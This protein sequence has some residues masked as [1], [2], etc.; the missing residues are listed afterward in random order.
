D[1]D[2]LG[3]LAVDASAKLNDER[4]DLLQA[5]EALAAELSGEPDPV[6]RSEEE[7]RISLRQLANVLADASALIEDTFAAQR[8]K[9]F[10]RLL[11]P[12]R[13]PQPASAH[14]AYMR[15][16]SPLEHVYT[17]ERATEICLDSLK[18]LGFDLAADP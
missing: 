9:W 18:A 14:A 17:K 15:R 2:E 4:R 13:E 5:N 10:D 1:R 11:G 8:E 3:D 6:S 16:L 7:K 12:E